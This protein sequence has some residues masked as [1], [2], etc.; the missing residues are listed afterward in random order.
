M[1]GREKKEK[2]LRKKFIKKKKSDGFCK[3][4]SMEKV[5]FRSLNIEFGKINEDYFVKDNNHGTVYLTAGDIERI[6]EAFRFDFIENLKAN[7]ILKNKEVY[8]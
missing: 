6:S 7:K 1:N 5:I 4:G 8:I 3:G 2:E